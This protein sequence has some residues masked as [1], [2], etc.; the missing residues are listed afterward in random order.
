MDFAWS[1]EEQRLYDEVVHFAKQEL[2]DDVVAR[3][4]A[5]AFPADLWRRCAS[6]GVLG[7]AVPKRL[8]GAGYSAL[9]SAHL[10]EALGY[11]CP[12]NGLT[13]ALGAQM[14]GL[15]KA[16]LHFGSEEQVE[17]YLRGSME[18]RLLGAYGMTEA[19]SGSDA[20]A[21]ETTARKDGDGYVLDGEKVL[22]TFAP[23]ADYAIIFARTDPDAG[24]WGL[25]A[26]LVDANTPGYTA[27][28]ADDKMGLRTVPFGRI[29][30]EQC[31]VPHDALLS[32]EG[33]GAGIFTFS[34]GWERG[35]VLA[36][37]LG[38]LQRL[39]D[40]CVGVARN[41]RR[42]GNPIGKH[43][44]VAHRIAN[45]KL[46]LETGRLLLYRTA[47]M[48]EQGHPNLMEAALTK[49]YLSET[50]ADSSMD[51]IAIHGGAGYQTQHAVERQL[52]DAIGGTIYGGTS[53][54]QRNIVAGLLGL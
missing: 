1:T 43:Q 49:I 37:Q 38:I 9:T 18:G 36:P 52:R 4:L 16:L 35:L 26:F 44:A 40:E 23:I 47:W 48:Q 33:T 42:G 8:G 30:L 7:W 41:R 12:D 27:H 15:Q 39:L 10:M 34:Q 25:S 46:R 19:G 29:T 14:W 22:V 28:A 20:F 6:F 54:I 51:A 21:L 3:D 31:R 50:F 24:R 17:R 11:G 32:R 53:D 5:G 2:H 13:F 45:M